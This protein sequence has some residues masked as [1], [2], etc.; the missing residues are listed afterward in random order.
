[1]EESEEEKKVLDMAAEIKKK[2]NMEESEEEKKILDITSEINVGFR[3]P[4]EYPYALGRLLWKIHKKKSSF[5]RKTI[6]R[7]EN[8]NK[9]KLSKVLSD[10]IKAFQK[11][12]NEKCTH[13][14]LCKKFKTLQ[15]ITEDMCKYAGIVMVNGNILSAARDI[16]NDKNLGYT[17]QN[18]KKIM[19]NQE[20]ENETRINGNN[21][22][23][24]IKDYSVRQNMNKTNSLRKYMEAV[25][26]R[27]EENKKRIAIVT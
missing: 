19:E 5:Q 12:H 4:K 21:D 20:N 10:E 8:E 25:D 7:L 16:L 27:R 11:T 15:Q 6:S 9:L 17:D 26:K 2:H 18:I 14:C 24:V 3:D 1:M 13:Y 23:E 22:Q